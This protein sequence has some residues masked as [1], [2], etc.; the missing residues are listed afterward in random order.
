MYEKE[1]PPIK[2]LICIGNDHISD[3]LYQYYSRSGAIRTVVAKNQGHINE[4]LYDEDF[5]LILIEQNLPSINGF[6]LYQN[7]LHRKKITQNKKALMFMDD[8][9]Q[10][11]VLKARQLGLRTIL[12]P[13]FTLQAVSDRTKQMFADWG[14]NT[15]ND[16]LA[17][18]AKKAPAKRAIRPVTKKPIRVSA[19]ALVNRA[20]K[21]K[22]EIK[23]E[24]KTVDSE[25]DVDRAMAAMAKRQQPAPQQTRP[26]RNTQRAKTSLSNHAK[27]VADEMALSHPYVGL[28]KLI[29]QH[30]TPAN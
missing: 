14:D 6:A 23:E 30:M 29:D 10:E 7:L 25:I 9:T 1:L 16:L 13:P 8:P 26:T 19:A 28:Q 18:I 2:V 27:Q 24:V 22:E 12:I 15:K 4:A 5:D 20:A 21:M 17:K 11:A 3:P